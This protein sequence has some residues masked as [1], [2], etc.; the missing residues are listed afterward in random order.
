[1]NNGTS[2]QLLD[3]LQWRYATKVFD[4]AKKITADVWQTLESALVLTP[5]SY[6]LQPYKFL[7]INDPAKRAELLPHSWNQKQVVD[8]SHF[9]V[10]TARTKI[11]DADVNKLIKLTSDVRKIPA[12]SLN[13]YRDLMLGDVVNGPRSKTAHD[14]A[15]RQ[16]YIALGNLM[17]CAAVLG[18]DACPME[19]FNPA[20]YDRVLGL[21]YSGYA[22]VVT[23]AL[24]YRAAGDKYASQPK[25]RYETNELVQQI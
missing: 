12:E 24:G 4:A 8:A 21:N 19:G 22:T 9:V 17:T 6:G 15:A 11:T 5:T 10:F 3:A 1:M 23:C 16:A 14:W 18:V 13:F 25:V 7:V 2:Q 20:E